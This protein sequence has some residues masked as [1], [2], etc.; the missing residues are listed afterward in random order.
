MN[1]GDYSYIEA[2]PNGGQRT[3]P[4]TGV[5][6]RRQLF[7][8]WVRPVP[9]ERAIFA[10]RAALREVE[11]LAKN[12]LTR[13]QFEA[14]RAFLKKYSYQ[15]ATTTS[16]RL[17]YAIDDRFYD[18]P[19][20]HLARFRTMMDELTLEEVNAAIRKHL[21][22][23]DLVIAMVTADAD[24][25]KQA[26]VSDAPSPIDYGEIPKPEEVLR[27]DKEIERY[28]LGIRAENVVVVP[29]DEMFAR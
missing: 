14:Q 18:I 7:E 22:A 28:P 3:M 19:E 20:G 1:Y 24:A 25:L 12:G 6:R 23:D 26:L 5:G 4:P 10:L 16:D 11:H 21:R 27:Q 29:V 15:F 13:E 9:H 8:L 2:F 17:G